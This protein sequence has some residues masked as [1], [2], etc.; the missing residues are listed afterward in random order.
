MKMIFVLLPKSGRCKPNEGRASR[1]LG[2]LRCNIALCFCENDALAK[3]DC[4]R[5][6]RTGSY[7]S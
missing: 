7:E 2:S 3:L 6:K 5:K 4:S 1:K